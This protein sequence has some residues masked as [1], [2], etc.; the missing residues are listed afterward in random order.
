MKQYKYGEYIPMHMAPKEWDSSDYLINNNILYNKYSK[1]FYPLTPLAARY[2]TAARYVLYALIDLTINNQLKSFTENRI[3]K[4]INENKKFYDDLIKKKIINVKYR[5]L[6]TKYL[7]CLRYRDNSTYINQ[8]KTESMLDIQAKYKK[9]NGGEFLNGDFRTII[10]LLM[11]SGFIGIDP[12]G[13]KGKFF[14]DK[15]MEKLYKLNKSG[16]LL[17]KKYIEENYLI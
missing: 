11:W 15:N 6:E 4:Q 2:C 13:L 14:E 3:K 1:E 7:N 10:G 12:K 9:V 17:K 5:S 8:K 16:Q